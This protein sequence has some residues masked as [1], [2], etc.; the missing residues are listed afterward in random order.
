MATSTYDDDVTFLSVPDAV[1]IAVYFVGILSIGLWASFRSTRSTLKGYFLAGGKMVWWSVGASLYASNIGSEHFVGLAGYGAARGITM[2]AYELIAMHA[3]L[4]LG[5]YFLPV[6]L[7][8]RVYTMPEYLYKRFG[9]Q[10]IRVYIAVISLLL[11][12]FTKTSVALYT[13]AIFIQQAI[14]WNIYLSVIILLS[15][16]SIYTVMGGLTTVIYTDAAQFVIMIGGA[17]VMMVLAFQRI[18][19][20]ELQFLYPISIPS[21]TMLSPNS[22]CGFP[23]ED[24]FRFFRHPVT[25]DMPWPAMILG[26]SVTVVWYH[27]TDQIMVQRTLAAKT[28]AH[29]KG[30]C[31]LAAIMKPLPLFAMVFPGMISRVLFTDAVACVDPDECEKYC[32][33][34]SGCTDIAYP[35]LVVNVMPEGLRGLMLAVVMSGLMSSLTS[36]FNSSSTIFTIDIW[37]RLRPKA[38]EREL[39]VVG[40]VFILMLVAFSVFWISIIQASH[41]GRLVDYIHSMTS[42]LS[43]PLCAVFLLAVTWPRTTEKA[44]FWGLM[45]GLL[46]GMTR[47]ATDLSFP[48]PHCGEIDTRPN[49]I[50]HWHYLYFGI[51]SFCII[52]TFTITVSLLTTPLPPKNTQGLT[53][54]TRKLELINEDPTTEVT[55]QKDE[56]VDTTEQ[57]EPSLTRRVVDMF[58]GTGRTKQ[59][60]PTEKDLAALQKLYS[61]K[62]SRLE[63][64]ILNIS[65]VVVIASSWFVFAY[66]A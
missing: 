45:L 43:P 33:N 12:V 41:G 59:T 52:M 48:E 38:K 53:W 26:I 54:P 50:A 60:T 35:K 40:R 21:E 10:R 29:A 66:F 3:F 22:S 9:G 57:G 55:S 15:I 25:S 65:A 16:T 63:K 64:I 61:L 30:G 31:V 8:A 13:G 1:V 2:A 6:F 46:I 20:E 27:C 32:Q 37:T 58:C 56:T 34:P 49:V 18:S 19:W 62:E 14:G 7:S 47:L 24:A 39:M 42:Y 36:I 4:L 28:L 5:W 51:L 23:R 11:A 44:A 17:I